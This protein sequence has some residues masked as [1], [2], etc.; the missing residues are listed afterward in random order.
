M[1]VPVSYT[2]LPRS[3][4]YT[5]V[6]VDN[7]LGNN[8]GNLLKER[9]LSVKMDSLSD[10][11]KGHSTKGIYQIISYRFIRHML[12][13]DVTCLQRDVVSQCIISLV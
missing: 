3:Y 7:I 9:V 2:H 1:S 8:V 5:L 11:C 10:R 6:T 4:N 13:F 12:M